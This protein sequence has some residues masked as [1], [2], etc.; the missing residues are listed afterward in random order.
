MRIDSCR[1]CG[2]ELT[3]SKLCKDCG[4][5]IKLDCKHCNR[6]VDDKIHFSCKTEKKQISL[7]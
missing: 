4:N 1:N 5:P 2:F 3:I 7:C 6:Y